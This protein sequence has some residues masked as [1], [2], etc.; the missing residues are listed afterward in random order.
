VPQSD[1]YSLGVTLYQMLAGR[2]PFEHENPNELALMHIGTPP[3]PLRHFNPDIPPGLEAVIMKSI[4][5]RVEARYQSGAEMSNA[6][7]Q[8]VKTSTT[9]GIRA[10]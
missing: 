5:K 1:L 7:R 2:L 8:M 9:T 4:A 6:L 3:P 10:G